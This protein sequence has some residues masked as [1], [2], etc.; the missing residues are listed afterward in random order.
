[1]LAVTIFT[2]KQSGRY[3]SYTLCKIDTKLSKRKKK[4]IES[5]RTRFNVNKE[6]APFIKGVAEG[7]G[8][9]TQGLS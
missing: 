2:R 5:Y 7:G 3:L 9:L 4:L 8:I 6:H 1:V